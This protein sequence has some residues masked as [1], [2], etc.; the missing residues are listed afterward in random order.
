MGEIEVNRWSANEFTYDLRVRKVAM[1]T[2]TIE[3]K[4]VALRDLLRKERQSVVPELLQKLDSASELVICTSKSEAISEELETFN[5][6]NRKNLF[7][8]LW[9][10][11]THLDKRLR[12]KRQLFSAWYIC[13]YAAEN[14]YNS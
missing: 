2:A 13:D 6:T 1:E 9:K 12:G 4:R 3:A 11:L 8:K 10:K 14:L 5:S 7:R